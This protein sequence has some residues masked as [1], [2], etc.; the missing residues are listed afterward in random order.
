MQTTL[1]MGMDANEL[2]KKIV[3][4]EKSL[5]KVL[6]LLGGNDLDKD[7]NGIVGTV[8]EHDK[9]IENLEKWKD[10]FVW[11]VIGLGLPSGI[12]VYEILKKIILKN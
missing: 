11:T 12:G 10:R 7:D 1:V 4:I 3:G 9:R 2:E 6:S 5:S 8:S